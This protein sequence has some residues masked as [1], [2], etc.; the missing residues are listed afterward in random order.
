MDKP[1]EHKP[2]K[3]NENARQP[4]PE[5]LNTTD[6]QEHMK[7]PISSIMQKGK[8]AAEHNDNT[9]KEKEKHEQK[10]NASGGD[11]INK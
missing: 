11:F 4:D 7:G 5:T 3:G 10:R 1:I 2:N 9:P 6:P 8:K